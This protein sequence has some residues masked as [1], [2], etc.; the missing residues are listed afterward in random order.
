MWKQHRKRGQLRLTDL[1][2]YVESHFFSLCIIERK[3]EPASPLLDP[4]SQAE[5]LYHLF[6]TTRRQKR[7]Q[8]AWDQGLLL[9]SAIELY[10][11][12]QSLQMVNIP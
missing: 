11:K 2:W 9:L 5:A 1:H 8:S 12:V 3:Q 7:Q 6:W 4:G 10:M